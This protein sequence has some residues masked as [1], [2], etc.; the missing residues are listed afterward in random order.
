MYVMV[1][2]NSDFKS[3]K[4]QVYLSLPNIGSCVLWWK[5]TFYPLYLQHNVMDWC[6]MQVIDW[7]HEDTQTSQFGKAVRPLFTE[8]ITHYFTSTQWMLNSSTLLIPPLHNVMFY[9]DCQFE[10]RASH[11]P[12][13]WYMELLTIADSL[14]DQALM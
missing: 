4:N 9:E 7:N 10:I 3:V 14:I 8:R 2:M 13:D 12:Q 1:I 11:L 5:K 6:N